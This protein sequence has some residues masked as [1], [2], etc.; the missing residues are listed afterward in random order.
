MEEDFEEE[1]KR[2][3]QREAERLADRQRLHERQLRE[4]EQKVQ[5][6]FSFMELSSLLRTICNKHSL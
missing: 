3:E 5:N 1:R 2:E 6:Y 4:R